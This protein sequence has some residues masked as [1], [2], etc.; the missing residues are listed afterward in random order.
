MKLTY[1][2]YKSKTN[3]YYEGVKFYL[4]VYGGSLGFNPS[5]SS[6]LDENYILVT[7][8]AKNLRQSQK[9][10]TLIQNEK[11]NKK[12]CWYSSIIL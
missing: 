3:H 6:K 2:E 11:I 4:N 8:R 12:Q 7:K 1:L 10:C 9:L 5:Q